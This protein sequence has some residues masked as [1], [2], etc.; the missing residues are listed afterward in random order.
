MTRILTH[1]ASK[2]RKCSRCGRT[3]SKGAKFAR[4]REQA[5]THHEAAHAGTMY[6][7]RRVCEACITKQHPGE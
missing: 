5:L 4:Y 1:V 2:P 6:P 3:I 7:V